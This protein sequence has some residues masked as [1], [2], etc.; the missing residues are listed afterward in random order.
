MRIHREGYRILL[1]I[2]ILLAGISAII[3]FFAG[4]RNV[5]NFVAL[6]DF[7]L[8]VFFLRFFRK[9]DRR[10][11]QNP[12]VVLAPADG[13]IVVVEETTEDEYF[14]D[15]RIQVSIF[16]SVWDV[17]INWFPV[18]GE[19]VYKK[20]HPGKYLIARHPKSSTE[21]ERSTVVIRRK[22]GTEILVRQIAGYVARKIS[23]YP[24]DGQAVNQGEE[25]GFI[26]FGSRVDVFLPLNAKVQVKLNEKSVGKISILADC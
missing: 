7:L 6:A 5:I 24:S 3:A 10:F 9:P 15:R 19:V 18:D 17:H 20:Y 16:M 14:H 11:I 1:I 26:K 2:F 21:N 22:D 25:L 13:E 23:T 8:L 12:N 4:S